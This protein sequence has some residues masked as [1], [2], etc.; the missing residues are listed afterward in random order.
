MQHLHSK[1][2]HT[3]KAPR[4]VDEVTEFVLA[5][6]KAAEDPASARMEAM[7]NFMVGID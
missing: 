7:M 5:G 1:P 4:L 2:I 6:A 3:V